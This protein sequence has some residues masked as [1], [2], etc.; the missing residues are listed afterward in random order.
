MKARSTGWTCSS[1]PCPTRRPA[2]ATYSSATATATGRT[3][4]AWSSTTSSTGI[5]LVIRGR[6]LLDATAGQLRL[7]RLLGRETP[8]SFLHHALIR[9][10][11]GSKLSK[12]DGDT[13]VRSLLAAGHTPG[14]LLGEAAAAVG[15][16][17]APRPVPAEA[18]GDLFA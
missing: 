15:L 16:L 3:A 13:A 14:E 11:D 4:S 1:A 9:K 10:A 7:A 12:A 8:P 2:P 5:D 6:D 17:D 18:L